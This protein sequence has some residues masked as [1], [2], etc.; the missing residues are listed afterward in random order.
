[1]VFHFSLF[2]N[3]REICQLPQD[4]CVYYIY[5]YQLY[6]D[7]PSMHLL[8]CVCFLYVQ[9]D[10]LMLS[11]CLINIGTTKTKVKSLSLAQPW[12]CLF[13]LVEILFPLSKPALSPGFILSFLTNWGRVPV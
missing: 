8:M 4:I 2:L 7:E 5:L 11:M 13:V 3:N 6:I 1:M 12:A 9:R 10:K